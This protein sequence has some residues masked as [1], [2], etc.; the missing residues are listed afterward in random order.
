MIGNSRIRGNLD[1]ANIGDSSSLGIGRKAGVNIMPTGYSNTFVGYYAG[2]KNTIGDYNSFFGALSGTNNTVGNDNSFFG[3]SAGQDNISG[4]SNVF[5]GRTAG[6]SNSSGN[7]NTFLGASA[8]Y[9]NTVGFANVFVGKESGFSN[10]VGYR[11][12]FNNAD[13]FQNIAIGQEALYATTQNY[14]IGIGTQ[15][16]YS[17]T[18]GQNNTAMGGFS[19]YSNNNANCTFIGYGSGST[20]GVTN[21]TALGYEAKVDNNN[22]VR[23]GN[24][25]VTVIEGNVAFSPMSDRRLKENIKTVDLGLK[26]IKDLHPVVYHRISNTEPDLEMGLIAQELDSVLMKHGATNIGMINRGSDGYLSVRYND[27][28]APLI[29]AIQE[30]Q[31]L[32]EEQTKFSDQL[33]KMIREEEA[34]N[35]QQEALIRNKKP[36]KKNNISN[37]RQHVRELS[38]VPSSVSSGELQ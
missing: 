13:G 6:K 28:F 30:Q 11:A 32:I 31:Q 36:K 17:N 22:K 16:L 19:G 15:S 18:T 14:N 23:I 9:E 26:F 4:S 7:D 27:L 10:K 33:L 8:G 25:F 29:K 24:G 1:I 12:L 35:A 2:F 21:G 20:V 38:G 3:T 37:G 34:I 5:F